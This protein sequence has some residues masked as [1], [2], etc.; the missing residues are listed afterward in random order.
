MANNDILRQRINSALA[1]F[2]EGPGDGYDMARACGLS[3]FSEFEEAVTPLLKRVP[4]DQRRMLLEGLYVVT[5][6]KLM[7]PSRMRGMEYMM[8]ELRKRRMLLSRTRAHIR[9]AR[10]AMAAAEATFPRLLPT[11][12]E[13]KETIERLSEFET[14]LAEREQG[15]AALVHP[16]FKTSTEKEIRPPEHSGATLPWTSNKSIQQWFIR[17]LDKCLPP[18]PKATRSPFARNKVIQKVL[19]VLGETVSIRTIIR[20]RRLR[21]TTAMGAKKK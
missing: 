10:E 18:P 14:D 7:K 13:F 2:V 9:N 3:S 20:A 8:A 17:A 12:F 6:E 11:S 21:N 16:R 15:L 4:S 5:A 19:K 1:V